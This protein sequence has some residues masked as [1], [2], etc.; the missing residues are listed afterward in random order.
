[1]IFLDGSRLTFDEFQRV[2]QQSEPV[3]IAPAALPAMLRSR[4][5]V[6]KLASLFKESSP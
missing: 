5:V 1:M 2:T 4:A 3:Q 6:E